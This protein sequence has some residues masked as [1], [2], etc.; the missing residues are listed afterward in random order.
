MYT[1]GG[2]VPEIGLD[3]FG[4]LLISDTGFMNPGVVFINTT[5]NTQAAGPVSTGL[6]PQA[7]AFVTVPSS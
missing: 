2:Y 3:P 5:D 4:Y 7:V 6:P 1:A